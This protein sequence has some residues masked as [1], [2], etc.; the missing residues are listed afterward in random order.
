LIHAATL[1]SRDPETADAILDRVDPIV[2]KQIL[3]GDS[4]LLHG[5]LRHGVVSDPAI[6]RW[7]H[8]G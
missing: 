4:R 2:E 7:N 8:S 3:G 5:I 6:Q 1:S